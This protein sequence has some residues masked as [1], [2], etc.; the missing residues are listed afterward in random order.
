[1]SPEELVEI[2]RRDQVA[3]CTEARCH[4]T[5]ADRRALLAHVFAL[6]DGLGKIT[7]I[8][9]EQLMNQ[10]LESGESVLEL[11]LEMSPGLRKRLLAVLEP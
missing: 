1:M 2:V 8:Y 10:R 3:E 5:A 9:L 6:R 7:S 11:A 4:Q